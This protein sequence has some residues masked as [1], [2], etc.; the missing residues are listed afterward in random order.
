MRVPSASQLLEVW[1]RGLAQPPV[2]RALLL[3]AVACPEKSLDDLARLSI[4]QRDA[5]LLTLREGMFGSQLNGVASCPQC[6]EG[7]ELTFNVADVRAAQVEP[8]ESL[9]LNAA[10]YQVQF[11][12]P[13]SLDLIAGSQAVAITQRLLV[14]RCVLSAHQNGQ[15]R[16]ADQLP[17]Q[18]V[19]AMQE[20]M[21]QA[22]PQAQVQL[23]V[24]CP[25]C[26]HP[27]Q[28]EFDIVSFLWAEV[29][30]FALRSLQQV[31][32]LALAYGWSEADI[33]AMT[34][35]RRQ[36]YLEMLGA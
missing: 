6:S 19:T 27:W 1:E 7:L 23:N 11:R 3:L 14:E 31:H 36:I 33:L 29:N 25:A 16:S 5:L 30:A 22:D 4:G 35:W 28:A 21:S 32:T 20:R 15:E 10:G 18:V 9:T 13:N 12:L 24:A 17:E 34:P 2:Q 8:D 26:G